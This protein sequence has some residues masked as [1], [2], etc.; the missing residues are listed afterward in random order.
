MADKKLIKLIQKQNNII[1]L[2]FFT[3][4]LLFLAFCYKEKMEA[5]FQ[6]KITE[7]AIQPYQPSKNT[8]FNLTDTANYWIAED[9]RIESNSALRQELAY[10]QELIIHT[11]KYL[12]P[13][14]LV[15]KNTNGMNCQNCHLDAGTKI[16]GNNYG[17]VTSMYPKMRARSGKIENVFK[18]I[19]DCFERSLNGKK[20]AINSREMKAIAKYINFI[21]KKVKKG[22]KAIGSGLKEIPLMTRAANPKN[23][24]L[25]YNQKCASCHQ[26]NGEGQFNFN[27]TEYIYPP[28]WGKYSYN[29]GAGL[30]RISNFAKFIKFNM[31]FGVNH[32]N[33][34]LSDE[35]SWDIAAF[36]NSQV[37]PH[38]DVPMDWPDK[39]KKPVDHPFGPYADNFT[40]LQHKFGPFTK[41]KI[42]K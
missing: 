17:S 12:G 25:A 30:Y 37:R 28:L 2:L 35:E 10:G 3:I 9:I 36:V 41:M 21:G 13:N 1:L 19:N 15:S 8:F 38:K 4:I 34:Q 29:D 7:T 40:E 39:A 42:K 14:G 5:F 26:T 31:P 16:F 18:R 33:A 23:G 24:M 32:T 11:S 27:K 22:E 6:L 20:L